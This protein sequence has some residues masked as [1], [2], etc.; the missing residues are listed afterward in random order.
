MPSDEVLIGATVTL[1]DL[2]TGKEVRYT[3][4]SEEEADYEHGR[5]S[6]T[7]PIGQGLIGHKVSQLVEIEVPAGV[8]TYK[9]LKIERV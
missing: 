9:V 3:L 1:K 8:F 5:I 2:D 7:S 6:V 4:V